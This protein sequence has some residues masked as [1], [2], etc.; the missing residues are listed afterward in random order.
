LIF[1]NQDTQAFLYSLHYKYPLKYLSIKLKKHLHNVH[2]DVCIGSSNKKP[3]SFQTPPI[4]VG[5]GAKNQAGLLAHGHCYQAPSHTKYSGKC[6]KLPFT[7]AGPR[8]IFTN[9]PIKSINGQAVYKTP[10]SLCIKFSADCYYT[11]IMSA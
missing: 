9:F 3:E 4:L 11:Q 1:F 2:G 6:L 5:C 10:D 8:W 7:V